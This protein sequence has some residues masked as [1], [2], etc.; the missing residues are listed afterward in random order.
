[1]PISD[2]FLIGAGGHAS[3][4]LDAWNGSED[5][6]ISIWD[7]DV[8]LKGRFCHGMPIQTPIDLGALPVQGHVAIGNNHIRRKLSMAIT[9]N[10][11]IL[12]TII[13][14]R[15]TV[16]LRSRLTDGVFVAA[17]AVVGPHVFL[18]CGVIV[19]HGAIVD[20]DTQVG[21]FTHIAPNATIGGGCI[22]GD[23]CLVGAGSTILPNVNIANN[24]VVAAGAV[25]TANFNQEGATL[26]GAPAISKHI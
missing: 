22:I 16:A 3:V 13:H 5:H 26:I 9:G 4:V 20:H 24:I 2:F 11:K 1:M 15:A 19:N 10:G 14:S 17:N 25:V 23:R 8:S 6:S 18:D 21:A 7:D 12:K